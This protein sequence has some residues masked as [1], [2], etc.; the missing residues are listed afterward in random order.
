MGM[1]GT[2]Q[3][4]SHSYISLY[5]TKELTDDKEYFYLKFKSPKTRYEIVYKSSKKLILGIHSKDSSF[6]RK[7]L[8]YVK[9]LL[10]SEN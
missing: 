10:E 2:I 7:F 3:E 4:F 1:K 9:E 8:K 6:K 5:C